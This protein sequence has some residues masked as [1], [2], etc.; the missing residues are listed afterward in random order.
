MSAAKAV[1][2]AKV[3]I[4]ARHYDVILSPVITEKGDH[5]LGAEQ[6]RVQRRQDRVQGSDPGRR[7]APV[8]RQG[9]QAST[10]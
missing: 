7:R 4:E 9:R 3:A 5:G 2:A 1:K 8:R 6:G 10:R